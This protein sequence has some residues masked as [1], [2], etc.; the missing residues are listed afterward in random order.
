MFDK[1]LRLRKFFKFIKEN[2]DTEIKREKKV[3]Y[4]PSMLC[5][6]KNIF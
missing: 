4:L 1:I 6:L 3:K 2:S 5:L